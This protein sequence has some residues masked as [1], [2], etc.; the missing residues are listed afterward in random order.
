VTVAWTHGR[1][2][3]LLASGTS[4]GHVIVWREIRS[5]DWQLVHQVNVTRAA[6]EV[7]FAPPE[8]G[9]A[10]AI[11][12]GDEIGIVTLL[13][14]K[15]QAGG[16]GGDQWQVRTFT[17]HEGGVAALSWGPSASAATLATGP[18]VGRAAIHAP[19][20]LATCGAD[21]AVCV[22]GTDAKLENWRKQD[23]LTADDFVGTPRDVAWRPNVGLPSSL[24]AAC[25][26][27]GC[28]A[29]WVQDMDGQPWRLR[30][31]WRV[32]GDARRLSWS[33][34]GALLAVSVGDEGTALYREGLGGAWEQVSSL[35]NE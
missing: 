23:T 15:E 1:F 10:L 24:V 21:G 29:I 26:D 8:Y 3:G 7:A 30:T 34:A 6:N 35:E 28:V 27:S 11:A 33:R 13:V 32:E 22:W 19:C 25:T 16:A 12:G 9:L 31:S 17:C 14:K 18:A 4:D 20:R 2:A 5:S